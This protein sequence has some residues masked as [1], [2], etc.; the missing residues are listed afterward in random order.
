M[1]MAIS[2]SGKKMSSRSNFCSFGSVQTEFTLRWRNIHK[3]VPEKRNIDDFLHSSFWSICDVNTQRPH[4]ENP[5]YYEEKSLSVQWWR[6]R[7]ILELPY[8]KICTAICASFIQ[9]FP[10]FRPTLFLIAHKGWL[11][12]SFWLNIWRWYY[13]QSTGMTKFSWYNTW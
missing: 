6:A 13:D 1:I 3:N 4:T 11:L 7:S 9:I 8:T 10:Y 5:K 2:R 12:V